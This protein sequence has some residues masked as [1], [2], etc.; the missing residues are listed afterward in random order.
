M[1]LYLHGQPYNSDLSKDGSGEEVQVEKLKRKQ[2]QGEQRR[3]ESRGR[4]AGRQ[5]G[6]TGTAC[7]PL[8][9]HTER[10]GYEAPPR[11]DLIGSPGSF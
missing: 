10:R 2:Q 11:W 8:S 9:V 7:R 1:A 4:T 5:E 6:S 3:L